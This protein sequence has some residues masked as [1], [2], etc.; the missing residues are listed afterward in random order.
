M[1]NTKVSTIDN[2]Q[3]ISMYESLCMSPEE[4]ATDL[5][6]PLEG[7]KLV[8]L[9]GSDKYREWLK[10]NNNR[11]SA[12]DSSLL[13]RE[14]KESLF[15][16]DDCK[17]A[18]R[19]ISELARGAEL[20]SVKLRASEFIINEHKGRNDVAVLGAQNFSITLINQAMINARKQMKKAEGVE[21]NIINLEKV[22]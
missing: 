22:S 4:I 11:E 21:D 14:E 2:M 18:A 16:T 9:G 6:Y 3:L 10:E 20:E 15:T 5:G 13:P 1:L 8:L 19:T 7:V 12:P 17:M